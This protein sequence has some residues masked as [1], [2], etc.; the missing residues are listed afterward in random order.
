M[1]RSVRVSARTPA[2]LRLDTDRKPL[3]MHTFIV[4]CDLW[5]VGVADDRSS[6]NIIT[7]YR[8]ARAR[9]ALALM[10]LR[11]IRDRKWVER[12]ARVGIN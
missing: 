11:D 8:L 12:T 1:A 2:N 4:I 9:T 3:N 6:M 7:G 5:F 10:R